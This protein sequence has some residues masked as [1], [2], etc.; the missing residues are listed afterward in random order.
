MDFFTEVPL[1][2]LFFDCQSG[3]SGD[4]IL[5]AVTN[6]GIPIGELRKEL[7][8]L[9]LSGYRLEAGTVKKKGITATD[10]TGLLTRNAGLVH[11]QKRQRE[12]KIHAIALMSF[13]PPIFLSLQPPLRR[14]HPRYPLIERTGHV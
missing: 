13:L 4:M 8:K 10:R 7:E 3:A 11:P 6:L 9:N 12:R 1:K 14:H 2:Y 5:G